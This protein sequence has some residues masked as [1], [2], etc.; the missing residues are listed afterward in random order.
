MKQWVCW[1]PNLILSF[2]Q[3]YHR[4]FF[5]VIY[6]KCQTNSKSNIITSYRKPP[7]PTYN[8]SR[9]KRKFMAISTNS[10]D[11]KSPLP[12][13]ITNQP[14]THPPNPATNTQK[15]NPTKNKN[16][17]IKNRTVEKSVHIL[18]KFRIGFTNHYFWIEMLNKRSRPNTKLLN[19]SSQWKVCMNNQ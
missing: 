18:S 9:P 15:L 8:S 14:A 19:H 7:L 11:T 3:V 6:N 4:Y 1:V 16:I 13:I 17:K 12:K 5:I 10:S 2:Y